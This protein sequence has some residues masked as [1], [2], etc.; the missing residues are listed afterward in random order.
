MYLSN[1]LRTTLRIYAPQSSEI[2]E[3]DAFLLAFA[4]S[5]AAAALSCGSQRAAL[6]ARC[7]SSQV[8][9]ELQRSCNAA[10]QPAAASAAAL[11]CSP[12]LLA[13]ALFQK[14]N[15]FEGPPGFRA[16]EPGSLHW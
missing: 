1:I 6:A 2:E 12:Q 10:L 9:S 15:T 5:S 4:I 13:A 3:S 11:R 14:Y 7:S 8:G 16:R